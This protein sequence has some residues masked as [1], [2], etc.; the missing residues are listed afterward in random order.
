MAY[1]GLGDTTLPR[2]TKFMPG[3]P[4]L[5]SEKICAFA[6]ATDPERA[7]AFYRDR[8]GLHL[9][10]EELPFA[11]VFDVNGIML[12]V[13]MVRELKPPGFTVLGWNVSDIEAAVRRLEQAGVKMERFDRVPQ[14]ELGIWTAPNG[15]QVA[16][17]KDPDGNI[18]SIAQH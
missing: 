13:Q 16:W 7:K 15:A 9:V 18:L 17:F 1:G 14:N 2:Q 5:A 3:S 8:L 6:A 11:L 12:R 4:P 10:R